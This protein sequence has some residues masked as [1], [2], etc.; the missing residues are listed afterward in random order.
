MTPPQQPHFLARG[1]IRATL[2][3]SR[4]ARRCVM[5]VPFSSPRPEDDKYQAT[6]RTSSTTAPAASIPSTASVVS[7]N[8]KQPQPGTHLA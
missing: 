1:G 7:R 6:P 4:D 5:R 2:A 3:Y 8:T